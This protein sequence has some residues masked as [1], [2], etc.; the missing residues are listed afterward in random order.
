MHGGVR[1]TLKI[2]DCEG[3]KFCKETSLTMGC[4]LR[5]RPPMSPSFRV[6]EPS[7]FS[8]TCVDLAGPLYVN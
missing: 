8:Y 3:K 4:L 2:L 5:N 1:N 6:Q 7:P